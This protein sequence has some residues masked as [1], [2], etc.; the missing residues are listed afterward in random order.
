MNYGTQYRS[1]R[2]GKARGPKNN[3]SENT[4]TVS[5]ATLLV[6]TH[7]S[8]NYIDNLKTL[9][10]STNRCIDEI[11]IMDANSTDG[12]VELLKRLQDP[13]IHLILS[14]EDG[15]YRKSL[16]QG[17][18]EARNEFIVS[19]NLDI[20]I[21]KGSICNLVQ[22]L[23]LNEK[24]GCVIPKVQQSGKYE[25]YFKSIHAIPFISIFNITD[26]ILEGDEDYAE[27]EVCGGPIFA[28]RKQAFLESGGLNSE[29]FM[30]NDEP[31][32][33]I[34]MGNLGYV[35]L[36]TKSTYVLHEWGSSVSDRDR[37]TQKIDFFIR[38][39]LFST[40]YLH[41]T[42]CGNEG[43]TKDKIWL[44]IYLWKS[45]QYC[46][47]R[48]KAY[49]FFLALDQLKKVRKYPKSGNYSFKWRFSIFLRSEFYEFVNYLR[50]RKLRYSNNFK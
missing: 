17:V 27:T 26:S 45:F 29:V 15:S 36:V 28:F 21:V 47:Y 41:K 22:L 11:L 10:T 4:A 39:W 33:S 37:N 23:N 31:E 32:M 48:K 20:E 40:A 44:L 25:P 19:I 38:N 24:V 6:I 9:I 13:R 8:K 7:N 42:M 49:Y 1:K 34:K 43:K 16:N 12:T 3:F 35:F 30:T 14:Q 50:M 18:R 2:G 46:V 5:V